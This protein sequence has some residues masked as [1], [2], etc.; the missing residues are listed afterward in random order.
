LK[1]SSRPHILFSYSTPWLLCLKWSLIFMC[2]SNIIESAL[3]R[4]DVWSIRIVHNNIALHQDS[5]SGL[6]PIDE[7]FAHYLYDHKPLN[8]E[9]YVLHFRVE[10]KIVRKCG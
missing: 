7:I 9:P 8:L 5:T 1:S 2:Q 10:I 6:V 4:V 3:S